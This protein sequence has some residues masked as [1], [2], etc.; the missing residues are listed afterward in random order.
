MPRNSESYF[1]SP[2]AMSANTAALWVCTWLSNL[3][4]RLYSS[5]RKSQRST[6]NLS[7][8]GQSNGHVGEK[9]PM[10]GICK[11]T[12][13]SADFTP[14]GQ[15]IKSSLPSLLWLSSMSFAMSTIGPSHVLRP[16]EPRPKVCGTVRRLPFAPTMM[17]LIAISPF[18]GD[19]LKTYFTVRYCGCSCVMR[20]RRPV[21]PT[22]KNQPVPRASATS[23]SCQPC[24]FSFHGHS[25]FSFTAYATCG[26]PA[27]R[28]IQ[29]NMRAS[30]FMRKGIE[31]M[32]RK[33]SIAI[34]TRTM[35]LSLKM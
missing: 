6:I 34:N 27:Q 15:T 23:R 9:R 1:L 22:F 26:I 21:G 28:V 29:A 11:A 20:A 4:A 17:S 19:F 18:A 13:F 5:A 10:A 30:F 14:P 24:N 3:P 12:I 35:R 25:P 31:G 7:D 32:M 8:R 33:R 2:L 16:R